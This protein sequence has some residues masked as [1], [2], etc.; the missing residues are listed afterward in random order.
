MEAKSVNADGVLLMEK[1][2]EAF[3]VMFGSLCKW[4]KRRI[5]ILSRKR[6]RN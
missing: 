6:M 3:Q 1:N 5:E 2:D 4:R